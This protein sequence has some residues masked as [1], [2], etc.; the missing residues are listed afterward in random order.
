MGLRLFL[1]ESLCYKMG[2]WSSKDVGLIKDII[3]PYQGLTVR[4]SLCCFGFD[5]LVS[6]PLHC[7]FCVHFLILLP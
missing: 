4:I 2:V 3:D 5:L 6:S 7:L 1:T